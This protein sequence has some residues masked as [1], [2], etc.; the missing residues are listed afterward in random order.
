MKWFT[1]NDQLYCVISHTLPCW[2][3]IDLHSVCSWVSPLCRV[4]NQGPVIRNKLPPLTKWWGVELFI[5][6]CLGSSEYKNGFM[7]LMKP[8]FIS[9]GVPHQLQ[10]HRSS[11]SP[12]TCSSLSSITDGAHT[13]VKTEV[14]LFFLE[15]ILSHYLLLIIIILS[16]YIALF[17]VP[18]DALHRAKINKHK[19]K[20]TKTANK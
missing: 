13:C 20:Y 16:T 11:Q 10:I 19:T 3:L 4:Y 17:K 8:Q 5:K 6:H 1:F 18:K 7:F 2:L 15:K 14:F 12:I 9:C